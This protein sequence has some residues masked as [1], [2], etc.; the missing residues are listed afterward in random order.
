ME[1]IATPLQDVWLIEPELQT[2]DRGFFARLYS[3]EDYRA[4]GLVPRFVQASVAFNRSKGTLR[5]M[6]WQADPHAEAKLV[7]CTRGAAYDVVLDLRRSSRT[8]R[9][10]YAVNLDA[11]ELHS[12]YVPAGCA[13][14]YQT[15][16]DATELSYLISS[17]YVPESAR[18]VRWNDP[19][20]AIRWPQC[21]RRILSDRDSSF[22]DFN[23]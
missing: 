5:G 17:L 9:Q 22:P 21:E 19:S 13:H 2:D 23:E 4:K 10:W 3:E 15:L 16:T 6:H 1:F 18:G 11:Q 8:Y 7:R 12:L 14:G 20:F